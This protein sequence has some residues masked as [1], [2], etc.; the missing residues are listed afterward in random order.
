MCRGGVACDHNRL[1]ILRREIV[2]DLTTIAADGVR[3]LR[4]IRDARRI[5]EVHDSFA[6]Q[7]P[8]DFADH[9]QAADAGVED[10]DGRCRSA[11]TP[12][13]PITDVASP[14]YGRRDRVP[15]R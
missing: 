14:A 12:L 9:G 6:R 8:D 7:L 5:A 3:A 15:E 11:H 2:G 13:T 1:D 10:A 4:A